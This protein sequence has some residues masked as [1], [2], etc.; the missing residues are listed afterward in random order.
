MQTEAKFLYKNVFFS[1]LRCTTTTTLSLEPNSDRKHKTQDRKDAISMAVFKLLGSRNVNIADGPLILSN[2][3]Q[4]LKVEETLLTTSRSSANQRK[5][6][7]HFTH[8]FKKKIFKFV[9]TSVG[10]KF[11]ISCMLIR[12]LVEW[13]DDLQNWWDKE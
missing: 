3:Q 2:A 10:A 11:S 13:T 1:N 12:R 5:R 7:L 4:K 9:P 6:I 8:L